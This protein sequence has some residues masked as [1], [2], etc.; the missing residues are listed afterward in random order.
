M[1]L[2]YALFPGAHSGETKVIKKLS[3]FFNF[4]ESGLEL[5][6]DN[7]LA[8]LTAES[9]GH[10]VNNEKYS[11]HSINFFVLYPVSVNETIYA[12]LQTAKGQY[13]AVTFYIISQGYDDWISNF[14]KL[15]DSEEYPGLIAKF[16]FLITL[17]E[18][19]T[20]FQ[21]TN[22][23]D[24]IRVSLG[25]LCF[26]CEQ[27]DRMQWVSFASTQ[28]PLPH[29]VETLNLKYN[30]Q[31]FGHPAFV[32]AV[33]SLRAPDDCEHKAYFTTQ[34][35][36]TDWNILLDIVF[37]KTNLSRK[38]GEG[39]FGTEIPT[40]PPRLQICAYCSSPPDNAFTTLAIQMVLVAYRY[41]KF[42]YCEKKTSF[43]TV[44]WSFFFE[45]LDEYTWFLLFASAACTALVNFNYQTGLS[46]FKWI[47][48]QRSEHIDS[49]R[50]RA[51]ASCAFIVLVIS[52]WYTSIITMNVVAPLPPYEF[53]TSKELF[54][55]GYRLIIKNNLAINT[56]KL[57]YKRDFAKKGIEF[58]KEYFD[59]Y[60]NVETSWGFFPMKKDLKRMVEMKGITMLPE[61]YTKVVFNKRKLGRTQNTGFNC[62]DVNEIIRTSRNHIWLQSL[63]ANRVYSVMHYVFSSG[64]HNFWESVL[65]KHM[66]FYSGLHQQNCTENC[67][68]FRKLSFSGP[69]SVAFMVILKYPLILANI[70]FVLEILNKRFVRRFLRFNSV[71]ILE[72]TYP[73]ATTQ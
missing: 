60:E 26:L 62:H 21:N 47:L 59:V 45:P 48:Q 46:L 17:C 1:D 10:G 31:G 36:C 20:R 49:F 67:D 19:D 61:K 2:S 39:V 55:A 5:G 35:L 43:S 63:L 9:T 32:N 14:L 44:K 34:P 53:S 66:I 13:E 69:I 42:Y 72:E 23:M 29:V 24:F 27:N 64:I 30:Q 37:D 65:T 73:T 40:G 57:N 56:I 33:F 38:P 4:S 16:V 18:F 52:Y 68:S 41:E 54:E 71:I 6:S 25:L 3:A 28:I 50:N 51:V 15:T 8:T 7:E 70:V 12:I 22:S 11:D 58:K